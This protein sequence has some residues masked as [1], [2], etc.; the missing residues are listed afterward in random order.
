MINASEYKPRIVPVLGDV[1][2]AEI[3]RAQSIDPTVS[4][5]REKVEEI[6]REEVVGYL[7]KSPTV[8]YRLTQLEYGSIEFWEKITNSNAKA[9][10]G[11][12]PITLDDFKTPYFDINAYLTDDDV[13][14]EVL[15]CTRL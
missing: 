3:D 1:D 12:N 7:K 13:R 5:N 2:S 4:L 8:G 11:E 10:S 15:I 6:G 9:G 14:S